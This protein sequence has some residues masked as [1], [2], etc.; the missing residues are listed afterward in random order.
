MTRKSTRRT[1]FNHTFEAW[2]AATV[3]VSAERNAKAS[4]KLQQLEPFHNLAPSED[5]S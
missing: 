4:F 2:E 1:N 3:T 5:R